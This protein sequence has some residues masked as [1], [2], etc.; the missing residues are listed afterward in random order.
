MALIVPQIGSYRFLTLQGVL[1]LA[2][3]CVEQ[4]PERIGID[5]T[6]YR[7]IGKRAR[8]SQ[9]TSEVD[10]LDKAAAKV[11]QQN[12]MNTRGTI[13]SVTT[14]QGNVYSNVLVV[15]V[16]VTEIPSHRSPSGGLVANSTYMVRAEWTLHSTEV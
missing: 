8:I 2:A 15:D 13:V 11:L 6:A 12:Y 14:E 16:R 10:V 5:G 1:D 7:K 9:M 3:E 4:L